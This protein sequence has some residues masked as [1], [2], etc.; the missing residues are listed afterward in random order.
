MY[1]YRY[2]SQLEN[3]LNQIEKDYILKTKHENIITAEVLDLKTKNLQAIK[4][5]EEKYEQ[6]ISEKIKDI[7]NKK[8][9]ENENVITTVKSI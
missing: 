8:N 2:K 5:I 3:R 4:E 6:Q 9:I 7:T 1:E